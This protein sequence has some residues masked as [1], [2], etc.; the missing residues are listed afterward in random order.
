MTIADELHLPRDP[1]ALPAPLR[2]A[3][4][5]TRDA[6]RASSPARLPEHELIESVSHVSDDDETHCGII[7]QLLGSTDGAAAVAHLVAARTSTVGVDDRLAG[8][9]AATEIRSFAARAAGVPRNRH[10]ALA[11]LKPLLLAASLILVA[12]TSWYVFTAP[13]RGDELR[14]A[15]AGLDLVSVPAAVAANAPISLRWHATREDVRYRI[16]V[17][18]ET[19]APVFSTETNQTGIELPA[20]A[21]RAGTYRWYVRA[22]ATDGTETRSRVE[23]FSVR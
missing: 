23:S 7:D 1:G 10:D 16:E 20:D 8:P 3:Y 13:K 18:D 4:A 6:A 22:R 11:G 2:D 14:S 15:D 5:W 9:Q 21:L 17:L 12:S 19:D